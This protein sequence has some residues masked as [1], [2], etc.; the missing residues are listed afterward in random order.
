MIVPDR[1]ARRELLRRTHMHMMRAVRA[2]LSEDHVALGRVAKRLGDPRLV[3][4][5]HQQSLD[6]REMRLARWVR[7]T[8]G[9]RRDA[10]SGL[11]RRLAYLHPRAVLTRERA[12]LSRASERLTRIWG[13][14]HAARSADVQRAGARLDAL[15]PLKVLARGYAIATR[16]DGT[17]VRS[18]ADV[19]KGDAIH[20][21]VRDARIEATVDA[22]TPVDDGATERE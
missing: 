18:A 20:L 14:A 8:L 5:A 19:R 16:D 10:L 4:A 12:E 1:T 17:A 15:S 3:I 6:D 21:R 2:R 11:Q 13:R 7:G 22:V 9:K